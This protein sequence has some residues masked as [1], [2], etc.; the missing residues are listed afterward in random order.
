MLKTFINRKPMFKNFNAL[1][2]DECIVKLANCEIING[3]IES[4]SDAVMAIED[5]E[6]K[7]HEVKF[8]NFLNSSKFSMSLT[9]VAQS[10][11]TINASFH[12]D[13]SE[14]KSYM[15]LNGNRYNMTQ[16]ENLLYLEMQNGVQVNAVRTASECL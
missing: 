7:V 9:S 12:F 14:G 2:G 1:N 6:G 16:I 8:S 13:I 4:S 3:A 11:I 10:C 15:L 5:N